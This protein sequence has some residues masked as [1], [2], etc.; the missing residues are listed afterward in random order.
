MYRAAE[1]KAVCLF[2]FGDKLVD[3]VVD[4]AESAGF[5]PIGSSFATL[6][7]S[8][9]TGDGFNPYPEDFAFNTSGIELFFNL[10]QGCIC[11]ALF[12]RAAI[13]Q[14]YFHLRT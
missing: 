8:Q 9:T 6:S 2:G 10:F 3:N 4:D 7:A 12:V 5:F 14:E 11:A 13:Y 1:N